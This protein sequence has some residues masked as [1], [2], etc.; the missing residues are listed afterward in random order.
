MD[1][2]KT[3]IVDDSP[4]FRK[5]FTMTLS[6]LFPTIVIEEAA[7]GKE[8]LQKVEALSPNLIFMDIQMPGENGITRTPIGGR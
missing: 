3:L 7:D 5:I 2:F 8:A 1:F 4:I 6:I